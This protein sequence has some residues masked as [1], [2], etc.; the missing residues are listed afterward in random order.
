MLGEKNKLYLQKK[1]MKN[2]RKHS[3]FF[4]ELTLH[5]WKIVKEQINKELTN[6]N[7]NKISKKEKEN[8]IFVDWVL[9]VYLNTTTL[10]WIFFENDIF[11]EYMHAYA[12]IYNMM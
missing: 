7:K 8:L 1:S 11:W 6:E 5:A 10:A 4:S 2:E 9:T 3:I 12:Y